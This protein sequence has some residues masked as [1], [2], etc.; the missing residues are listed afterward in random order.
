MIVYWCNPLLVKESF[1]SCHMDILVL[2]FLLGALL[3]LSR[4]QMLRSTFLLTLAIATKVWPLLLWPLWIRVLWGQPRKVVLH[5]ALVSILL[6]GLLYPMISEGL[7]PATGMVAYGKIWEMNDAA[8]M[9]VR[10]AVQIV[11]LLDVN[12]VEAV[13]RVIVGLLLMAWIAY[14]IVLPIESARD[15]SVRCVMILA[16]AFLLSPTQF[17]WYFIWTLP[18]LAA[19]RQWA[20][21]ILTCLLPL[22]YLRF[23]MEELG[24]VSLFDNGIVWIEF[25]PTWVLLLREGLA[26]RFRLVAANSFKVGPDHHWSP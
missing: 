10:K 7:S 26:K 15:L 19:Y 24:Q 23:R 11:G 5:L 21:L 20:M 6:V 22:Y 12:Q 18:F 14:V 8:F 16:A 4:K 2:P 3:C 1:N 25:L 17:P 13:S 9:V